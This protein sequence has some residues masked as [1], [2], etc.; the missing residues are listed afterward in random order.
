M[1]AADT[2]LESAFAESLAEFGEDVTVG[3]VVVSAVVTA[4]ALDA[5]FVDG[6]TGEG[7]GKSIAVAKTAL[8][9]MP[10]KMTACI[11]RGQTL[12]VLQVFDRLIHWQI[13]LGNLS[14]R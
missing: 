5:Q 8:V 4:A 11:V 3:G 2:A 9:S 12:Q 13:S 10:A 7:G 6:G 1:T 14:A